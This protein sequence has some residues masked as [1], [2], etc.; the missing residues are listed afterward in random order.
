MLEKEAEELR[1]RQERLEQERMALEMEKNRLLQLDDKALMVELIFAV[2]GFHEELSAIK[3]RQGELES[4]LADLDERLDSL[5]DD[6]DA[7][8]SKVYSSED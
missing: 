7:L 6:V 5:A 1:V 8:E 3:E 2:R 4:D